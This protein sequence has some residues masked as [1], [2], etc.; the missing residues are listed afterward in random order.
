[1]AKPKIESHP[2]F[3]FMQACS[4]GR[5]GPAGNAEY[6]L[7]ITT[8]V[9]SHRARRAIFCLL[10]MSHCYVSLRVGMR[11]PTHLSTTDLD[12][13]LISNDKAPEAYHEIP[14]ITQIES[15]SIALMRLT[16]ERL[17]AFALVELSKHL[18]QRSFCDYFGSWVVQGAISFRPRKAIGHLE[19]VP[20]LE[21]GDWDYVNP[22]QN[23][24]RRHWTSSGRLSQDLPCRFGVDGVECCSCLLED[25]FRPMDQVPMCPYQ[26][27]D[28]RKT[29]TFNTS[30]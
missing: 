1:M 22:I 16:V 8:H 25:V 21:S 28:K 7:M 6:A 11:S 29:W 27:P 9:D 23:Q 10:R 13:I 15:R 12:T 26:Y 20:A 3:Q 18:H 4:A 5:I 17:M 14:L 24:L 19:H 30:C 2:G